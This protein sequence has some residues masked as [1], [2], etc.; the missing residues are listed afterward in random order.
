MLK[1]ITKTLALASFVLLTACQTVPK[2]VQNMPD[3]LEITLQGDAADV[4]QVQK[5][6]IGMKNASKAVSLRL[7][8][9]TSQPLGILYSADWT[10][11]TGSP[12]EVGNS[13]AVKV[14][15]AGSRANVFIP[16]NSGQSENAEI[17]IA[18]KELERSALTLNE[19]DYKEMMSAVIADFRMQFGQSKK[20]TRNHR[21]KVAIDYMKNNTDD[22]TVAIKNIVVFANKALQNTGEFIVVNKNVDDIKVHLRLV[23]QG[24]LTDTS[25]KTAKYTLIL[26]ARDNQ[27]AE[28]TS[29]S[30]V[31]FTKE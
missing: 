20:T 9:T 15:K 13:R 12:T 16:A 30:T 22:S 23:M 5:P 18:L 6:W 10:D 21:M 1:I 17:S 8:N 7:V 26:T 29:S 19:D 2:E 27:G 3:G 25:G 14:I 11:A 4:I 31:T 28:K 24:G